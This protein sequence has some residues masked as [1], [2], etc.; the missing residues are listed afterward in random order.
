MRKG[1]RK[2]TKGRRDKGGKKKGRR[3]R[4]K[5]LE[6]VAGKKGGIRVRL[7]RWKKDRKMERG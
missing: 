6:G 1:R 2:G 7:W 4:V 3:S 5:G